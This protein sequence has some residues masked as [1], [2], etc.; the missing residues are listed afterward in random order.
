M[1][2]ELPSRWYGPRGWTLSLGEYDG[3]PEHQGAI[4]TTMF[5]KQSGRVIWTTTTVYSSKELRDAILQSGMEHG[6][7]EVMGRPAEPLTT[8]IEE[9]SNDMGERAHALAAKFEEA[10]ADAI[11]TVDRLS[12]ADWQKLTGEGWTVA[13]TAH[14]AAI[15][16]EGIVNFVREVAS[17]TATPRSNMDTINESNA[18][19]AEA[20]AT[21]S[22]AEV[23]EE[24]RSQGAAAAA[25]VR[26]LSDEQLDRSTDAIP[27]MPPVTAAQLVE[28]AL[29]GHVREHT[30]SIQQA[31]GG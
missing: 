2:S 26:G 18:A 23:L 27:G 28:M 12:D 6:V 1:K 31:I 20:F 29:I 9:E 8:T 10:N 5:T 7:G 24:F 22:K 16:H 4:V 3:W 30:V 14:H 25:I 11:A 17:G 21:C 19:H 15:V 13:A